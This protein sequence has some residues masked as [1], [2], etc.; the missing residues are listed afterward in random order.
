MSEERLG[1]IEA[2]MEQLIQMVAKSNQIV[3][4][5]QQL[6]QENNKI[7]QQNT[8]MVKELTE[9]VRRDREVNEAR[10][11]EL[12]KEIR[13][14]AYDIDYLRNVVSKH[15]MELHKFRVSQ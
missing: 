2:H 4:E 9:E 10:H 6:V 3:M 15:D 7:V 5:N 11:K 1:R 12:L 8:N 14:N 13:N